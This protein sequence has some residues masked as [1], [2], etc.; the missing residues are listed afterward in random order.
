MTSDHFDDENLMRLVAMRQQDALGALYDRY[1]RLVYTIAL[2]ACGD[3]GE[4]EEITQDVFLRV[5]QRAETYNPEQGKVY[6]WLARIARNRSIDLLRSRRSRL[7]QGS[8]SWE[9]LLVEPAAAQDV[10]WEAELD[11]ERQRLRRSI[12]QLPAEQQQVLALAYFKGLT[13]REIASLQGVPLGTVKT[14]IRLAMQK[15]RE[16]LNE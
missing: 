5:W 12:S 4:A 6:S 2:R 14:R 11:D 9:D 16:F 1:N 3:Q 8:L 13:E 7:D 10:Q 15:L